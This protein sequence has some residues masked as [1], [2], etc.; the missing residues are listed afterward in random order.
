MTKKFLILLTFMIGTLTAHGEDYAYLTFETT[1]GAKI[2][3]E[4]SSLTITI[5]GTTLTA[6][7]QS[8][9]LSDLSRMF[10]SSSDE[11]TTI[12]KADN[13]LAFSSTTATAKMGEAYAAPTL[14]N[15]YNLSLTWT[16]SDESVAT[17]DQT[18]TVTLIAAGTTIIT[19]TFAGS[20]DYEAGS[21]NYTLTV[22][23]ADPVANGLAF[24]STTATAKRGEAYTA[25]TLT[26]PYNLSLTWTSSD[27]S[28]ATVDQTGTVTLIAA[29]TTII[30]ATFAGS[31]DY[32]AG[33]ISYT[34]TVEEI[35]TGIGSIETDSSYYIIYNTSGVL[36]GKIKSLDELKLTLR[37]GVY[38]VTGNGKTYKMNITNKH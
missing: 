21:I 35:E 16:S 37:P 6:G 29:G 20:D 38:I 14:T 34:L 28:V 3:V 1:N 32:E 5:S 9:T 4:A 30:T 2:S 22:E 8:F 23:K 25:P 11:S 19:A 10:F 18:G 27:E 31:D 26:N 24:S 15:P 12:N 33:S 13:G 7:S 36:I 17:V